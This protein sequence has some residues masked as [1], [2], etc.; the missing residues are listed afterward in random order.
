MPR[1]DAAR[2]LNRGLEATPCRRC[3]KLCPADAIALA[4]GVPQIDPERCTECE[5]CAAA[6][7]SDAIAGTNP[8]LAWL[9]LLTQAEGCTEITVACEACHAQADARIP[10]HAAWP[11][12][13]L[14]ALAAIGVRRIHCAGL[15]QCET[16]P[17]RFGAQVVAQLQRAL[18]DWQRASGQS[19]ELVAA[20]AEAGK[21]TIPPRRRFFRML[22]PALVEGLREVARGLH[23]AQREEPAPSPA[24]PAPS[25]FWRLALIRHAVGRADV[26]YSR[27]PLAPHW[28]LGSIQAGEGCTG[29]E[30]CVALCPSDALAMQPFGEHKALMFAPDRC[31]GCGRCVAGCPEEVLQALPAVALPNLKGHPVRPLTLA[32]ASQGGGNGRDDRSASSA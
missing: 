21:Q 4:R 28:P 9:S 8:P 15:L 29:C 16:C 25:R 24:R 23:E 26:R 1:I 6:C 30:Q 13:V 11:L 19:I 18:S 5:A 3:E 7:P 27:L 12:S 10:C 32:P 20:S 14:V 31:I 2:C 17:R 22:S